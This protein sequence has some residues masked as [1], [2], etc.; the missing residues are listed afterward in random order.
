MKNIIY[1][2]QCLNPGLKEVERIVYINEKKLG[3]IESFKERLKIKET[4][5]NK[6]SISYNRNSEYSVHFDIEI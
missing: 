1:V 5:E 2:L 6:Y 3:N 4:L